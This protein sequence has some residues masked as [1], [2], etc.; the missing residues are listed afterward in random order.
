VTKS[1]R[2]VCPICGL[3]LPVGAIRGH[4][5]QTRCLVYFARRDKQFFDQMHGEQAFKLAM[6][7]DAVIESYRKGGA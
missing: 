5:G 2:V 7:L 6:Q 1:A 3:N 4:I